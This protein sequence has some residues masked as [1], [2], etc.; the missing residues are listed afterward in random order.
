MPVLLMLRK[1][2]LTISKLYVYSASFTLLYL[3]PNLKKTKKTPNISISSK[4]SI[5]HLLFAQSKDK[6]VLQRE[7]VWLSA[8]I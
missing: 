1:S 7:I 2:L 6:F 3:L 4:T 8:E 5:V